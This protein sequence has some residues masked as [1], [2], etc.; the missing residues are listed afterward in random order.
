MTYVEDILLSNVN[1]DSKSEQALISIVTVLNSL[2][3]NFPDFSCNDLVENIALL[4]KTLDHNIV[5]NNDLMSRNV[6]LTCEIFQLK[7][8]LE[9]FKI[10]KRSELDKSF[11]VQ[12]EVIEENK[13][14]GKNLLS[15]QSK[16]ASLEC[17]LK[18]LKR[19]NEVLKTT[20]SHEDTLSD[21]DFKGPSDSS[22]YLEESLAVKEKS[23]QVLASKLSDSV[24]ISTSLYTD[25]QKL[26]SLNARLNTMIADKWLDDSIVQAYFSSFNESSQASLSKALF[27]G[28]GTSELLKHGSPEVVKGQLLDLNYDTVK[29]AFFCVNNNVNLEWNG[30]ADSNKSGHGSHWSLLFVNVTDKEAF[31]LDSLGNLNEKYALYLSGKLGIG[32]DNFHSVSCTKQNN[33]FECGLNLILNAKI[34]LNC[35]CPT[36]AKSQ[37]NFISWFKAFSDGHVVEENETVCL[38]DPPVSQPVNNSCSR[39]PLALTFKRVDS[40]RWQI[41]NYNKPRLTS[42]QTPSLLPAVATSNRFDSLASQDDSLP[43]PIRTDDLSSPPVFTKKPKLKETQPKPRLNSH[44]TSQCKD[45]PSEKPLGSRMV[46]IFSDSHGRHLSSILQSNLKD[47]YKVVGTVKPGAKMDQVLDRVKESSTSLGSDDCIIIIG[48]TNNFDVNGRCGSFDRTINDFFKNVTKP[49]V[50]VIGLPNRYDYPHLN[51]A[52]SRMNSKIQTLASSHKNVTFVPVVSLTRPNYT[53]EGLHFNSK[54]KRSLSAILT[55]LICKPI[56]SYSTSEPASMPIPNNKLRNFGNQRP[57]CFK[58]STSSIAS[59]NPHITSSAR[60]SHSSKSRTI[61]NSHFLGEARRPVGVPWGWFLGRM[62]P[63]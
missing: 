41:V 59:K 60:S 15:C 27:V 8:Y 44:N 5:K 28:P 62:T 13:S 16:I 4:V 19:E 35:Y 26:Q 31:H 49:R 9:N 42:R 2:L 18:E 22:E 56:P 20:I 61:T 6:D 55:K 48:G 33:N 57:T 54:G 25:L 50:F 24:R 23:L 17:S 39:P 32:K 38:P 40:E 52:V 43:D 51:Q 12:D 1:L 45:L 47:L 63:A 11:Q 58:P 37:I 14:L 53:D 10:S 7:A 3:S 21:S 46:R 30:D 29:F 34:I 36:S